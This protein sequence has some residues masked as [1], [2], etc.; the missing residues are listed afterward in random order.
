M[1]LNPNIVNGVNGLDVVGALRAGA[2]AGVAQRDYNR[3]NALAALYQQQGAGLVRGDQGAVNA[4]AALDPQAAMKVQ[5]TQMDMQ[6]ARQ[7]MAYDAE[8][9]Q[10]QREE[11]RRAAEA[12][13]AKIGADQAVAMAAKIERGL[14]AATAA[15]SPEQ[16]DQIVTQFGASDLVGQFDSRDAIINSYLGVSEGLKRVTPEAAKPMAAGDRFKVVGNT[17]MDLGAEG[18][19]KP[20]YDAP[21]PTETIFGPD[22]NPIVQRGGNAPIKLTEAQ[23]KDNVYLTRAQGAMA[24]L[25]AVGPEALASYGDNFKEAVP[26]GVARGLQSDQFQQAKQAGDEYLQAILRKDTGAAI[27]AGEQ[28]LYG[29]TYLPRPGE[30]EAVIEAKRVSRI[31]A[32]EAI[33]SGMSPQ[34]QVLVDMANIEAARKAGA[35]QGNAPAAPAQN[36]APAQTPA[37]TTRLRFN[38]QTGELE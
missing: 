34:Q 14:A 20:V 5:A 25:D 27:T 1:P 11:A 4:L 2:E 12:H 24:V 22:G 15:K 30:S 31:R 8:R 7:G 19:P 16:W 33:R 6:N 23:S 18:G 13:A 28:D 35:G 21:Q 26:F 9:M 29:A 17:L 37:P 3:Q 38:P 36:P 32:I 10:M